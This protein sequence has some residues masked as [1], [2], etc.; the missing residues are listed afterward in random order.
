MEEGEEESSAPNAGVA[1]RW[2]HPSPSSEPRGGTSV[3]PRVTD[4]ISTRAPERRKRADKN[5][6]RAR[7]MPTE[8]VEHRRNTKERTPWKPSTSLTASS[9]WRIRQPT[10]ALA[11]C[12]LNWL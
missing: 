9:N 1:R 8:G 11:K 10:S 5:G 3:A 4:A 7:T 12:S 2:S 6:R